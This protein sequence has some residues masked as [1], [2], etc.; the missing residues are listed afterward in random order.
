MTN[1][2]NVCVTHSNQLWVIN[3][4]KLSVP[5]KVAN[6]QVCNP[7][8]DVV[9]D[10]YS[11]CIAGYQLNVSS[12]ASI[13][14][15]LRHAMLP[16]KPQVQ[17]ETCC[18]WE[19]HGIPEGIVIDMASDLDPSALDQITHHLGCQFHQR[20]SPPEGGS[21]ERFFLTANHDCFA[22]L[23]GF[24][25]IP[26]QPPAN[27]EVYL[28]LQQLEQIVGHYIVDNY[29]QRPYP[30]APNQTRS[31]RWKEGLINQP[32]GPS[33]QTLDDLFIPPS[34]RRVQK[35]GQLTF[36]NLVY[37]SEQLLTRVGELVVVRHNPTDMSTI[38]VYQ[39]NNGQEVFLGHAF[40]VPMS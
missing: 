36:R 27:R 2:T 4:S 38:S 29:N 20:V 1:E 18:D 28:E 3:R 21:V 19:I 30:K 17:Y 23:P 15:V 33:E 10:L 8:L 11:G 14:T 31:Q 12:D 9:G 22:L 16:K 6:D 32:A 35:F 26:Q 13:L 5:V 40:A 24:N 37:R 39:Q 34:Q 7:F 25:E